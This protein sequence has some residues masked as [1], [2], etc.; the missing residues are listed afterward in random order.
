MLEREWICTNKDCR[1]ATL[2][3]GETES[4]ISAPKCLCGASLKKCYMPPHF[5]S[6]EGKELESAKEL[7]PLTSAT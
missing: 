3:I 6:L 2:L 5:K 7:F 4:G 1:I